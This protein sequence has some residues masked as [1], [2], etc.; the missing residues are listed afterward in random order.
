MGREHQ[1]WGVLSL[2]TC[3]PLVSAAKAPAETIPRAASREPRPEASA[4]MRLAQDVA[5]VPVDEPSLVVLGPLK[6]HRLEDTPGLDANARARLHDAILRV[7]GSAV[8][9]ARIREKRA[10]SLGEARRLSRQ[11]KLPLVYL[12][13][14]LSGG[15]L[16][17]QFELV[18]WPHS[19]WQRALNPEGSVTESRIFRVKADASIRRHLPPARGLFS[20]SKA[21]KSPLSS[22]AALSCGD[23]D[24]D[25]ESELVVL[26]RREV[27]W[28]RFAGDQFQQE[29]SV[30]L[31]ELSPISQAP[32]RAPLA[33][34][35]IFQDGL[36]IGSSDRQDALLLDTKLHVVERLGPRL[37]LLSGDCLSFNDRGLDLKRQDCRE[38][39]LRASNQLSLDAMARG[40]LTEAN[41]TVTVVEAIVE[42]GTGVASISVERAASA[43]LHLQLE[44]VGNAVAWA[45][46]DGDGTIEFISSRS[47][48]DPK[49]DGLLVHTL[50]GDQLFEEKSL[51]VGPVRAV[52]V[53]PF[54]GHNPLTVVAAIGTDLWALY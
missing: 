22:I 16:E 39:T 51:P 14:S 6:E 32:L 24:Q 47:V 27:M 46:L 15:F 19:F 38:K 8:G 2:L 25:G 1:L 54:T 30:P 49:D 29:A 34:A 9:N 33:G 7:V 53:C 11:K 17:L 37:P 40:T 10:L 31:S 23:L 35:F 5:Q 13:P 18:L 26:G 44:N 4:L 42:N 52:T 50:K 41:G 21:F 36:L 28:G 20:E 3:I 43:T 48:D 12:E 45:D